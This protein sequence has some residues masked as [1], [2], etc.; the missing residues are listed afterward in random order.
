MCSVICLTPLQMYACLSENESD[1]DRKWNSPNTLFIQIY[2]FCVEESDIQFIFDRPQNPVKYLYIYKS[3][4]S[5]FILF[6]L[7]N[8]RRCFIL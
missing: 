4:Q 8:E 6:I 7:K 5:I 3:Q 2:S 1:I